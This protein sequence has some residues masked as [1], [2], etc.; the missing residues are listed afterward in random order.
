MK[1]KNNRGKVIKGEG[2]EKDKNGNGGGKHEDFI[3][4]LILVKT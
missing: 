4:A 2:K 1:K 3:Y